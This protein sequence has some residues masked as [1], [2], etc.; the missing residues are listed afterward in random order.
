MALL[1]II[2]ILLGSGLQA[3][4]FGLALYQSVSTRRRQIP[5]ALSIYTLAAR[6]VAARARRIRDGAVPLLRRALAKLGVR[7]KVRV[8]ARSTLRMGGSVRAS[9]VAI[10]AS[11]TLEERVALLET[12]LQELQPLLE[13]RIED[14]IAVVESRRTDELRKSLHLEELG[15]GAFLLGLAVTTFGVLA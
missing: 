10:R 5:D 9:G 12:D 4:G 7:W 14:A 11:K 3:G 6:R 1:N 2:L 15:V 13:Q 8:G